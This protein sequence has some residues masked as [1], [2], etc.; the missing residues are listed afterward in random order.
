M[1]LDTKKN[2]LWPF[3]YENK[4]N[5]TALAPCQISSQKFVKKNMPKIEAKMCQI[6]LVWF[7]HF[8]VITL[9]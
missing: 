5:K 9:A 2:K 3:S 7:G 1:D 6:L 4:A 8:L